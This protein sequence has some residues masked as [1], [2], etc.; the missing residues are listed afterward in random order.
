MIEAGGKKTKDRSWQTYWC[1]L[2]GVSLEFHKVDGVKSEGFKPPP[3]DIYP[4]PHMA[5]HKAGFVSVAGATAGDDY[6]S[7]IGKD[8]QKRRSWLFELTL[9]NQT[10]YLLQ[11]PNGTQRA[12]WIQHIR[13]SASGQED[14]VESR[15]LK[16]ARCSVRHRSRQNVFSLKAGQVVHR[17]EED[18]EL[19]TAVGDNTCTHMLQEMLRAKK[20]LLSQ[21][22]RMCNSF[23]GDTLQLHSEDIQ[24][25]PELVSSPQRLVFP[26]PAFSSV[27]NFPQRASTGVF[28]ATTLPQPPTRVTCHLLKDYLLVPG[29]SWSQLRLGD[30]VVVTGRLANGWFRCFAQRDVTPP[31]QQDVLFPPPHLPDPNMDYRLPPS[32]RHSAASTTIPEALSPTPE[33]ADSPSRTMEWDTGTG[34]VTAELSAPDSVDTGIEEDTCSLQDSNASHN[35][36]TLPHD[37]TSDQSARYQDSTPHIMHVGRS[38]SYIAATQTNPESSL[39]FRNPRRSLDYSLLNKKIVEDVAPLEMERKK[40]FLL[41]KLLLKLSEPHSHSYRF[42]LVGVI[43]PSVVEKVPGICDIPL[44][45]SAVYSQPPS[46]PIGPAVNAPSPAHSSTQLGSPNHSSKQLICNHLQ[47]VC[48]TVVAREA[49]R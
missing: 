23:L 24:K 36:E 38:Y 13:R 28:G 40:T 35:Q 11:A 4:P 12:Q 27:D 41:E 47:F 7:Q 19:V 43:P 16:A 8:L 20:E 2:K 31:S 49:I 34:S 37:G 48:A 18:V 1:Q 45:S 5:Q 9:S 46:Y 39:L 30:E 25:V 10:V 3:R 22:N 44:I 15:K 33:A 32:H 21:M 29:A 6:T 42:P 17:G 26:S 14:D